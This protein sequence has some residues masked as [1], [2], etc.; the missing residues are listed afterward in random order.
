MLLHP[1]P[2]TVETAKLLNRVSSAH[3]QAD[4]AT[5]DSFSIF[6]ASSVNDARQKLKANLDAA[7]SFPPLEYVCCIR[8]QANPN[9]VLTWVQLGIHDL[10]LLSA[11]CHKGR[12]C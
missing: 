5:P 8:M 10:R 6:D 4:E 7:V 1:N 3:L 9:W 11:G 12:P 2:E